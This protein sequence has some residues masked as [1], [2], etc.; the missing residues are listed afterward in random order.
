MVLAYHHYEGLPSRNL[1]IECL[2]RIRKCAYVSNPVGADVGRIKAPLICSREDEIG[3]GA[4]GIGIDVHAL[5][6]TSG[7]SERI[8]IVMVRSRITK[9]RARRSWWTGLWNTARDEFIS[10]G[11]SPVPI[12]PVI[13]IGVQLGDPVGVGVGEPPPPVSTARMN[14]EW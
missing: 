14:M 3:A 7:I 5:S 11:G 10:L 12:I 9:D 4:R 1:N 6:R 8:R 13:T 2:I